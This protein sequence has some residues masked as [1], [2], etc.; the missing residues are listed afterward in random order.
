MAVN[1]TAHFVCDTPSTCNQSIHSSKAPS[2][3]IISTCFIIAPT[4]PLYLAL[5]ARAQSSNLNPFTVSHQSL[6]SSYV[7]PCITFNHFVLP[8]LLFWINC[9]FSTVKLINCSVLHLCLWKGFF[10]FPQILSTA[11]QKALQRYIDA[12]CASKTPNAP[13][14]LAAARINNCAVIR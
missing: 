14:I 6:V 1:K 12:V 2:S 13:L 4:P 7:V 9:R 5:P 11:L 10:Y 3:R 8:H